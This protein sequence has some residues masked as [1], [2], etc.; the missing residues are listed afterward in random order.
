VPIK[1]VEGLEDGGRVP[2]DSIVLAVFPLE[3]L[4]GEGGIKEQV[5]FANLDESQLRA[6]ESEMLFTGVMVICVIPVCP[7]VIGTLELP[8]PIVKSGR[9]TVTYALATVEA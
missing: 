6:T 4:K 3:T 1:V 5:T 2:M 7:A 9:F 8:A